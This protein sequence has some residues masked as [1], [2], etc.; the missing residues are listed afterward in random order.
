MIYR[1]SGLTLPEIP[2][3]GHVPRKI[4]LTAFSAAAVILQRESHIAEAGAA[5]MTGSLLHAGSVVLLESAARLKDSAVPHEEPQWVTNGLT[6][7]SNLGMRFYKQRGAFEGY[8][9]ALRW[10]AGFRTYEDRANL[11]N[12]SGYRD[13]PKPWIRSLDH[14]EPR[15]DPEPMTRIGELLLSRN[16]IALLHGLYDRPDCTATSRT[17]WVLAARPYRDAIG[18]PWTLGSLRKA[19]GNVHSAWITTTEN[20]KLTHHTLSARGCAIIEREIPVSIRGYGRYYGMHPFRR[21]RRA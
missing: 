4:T 16:E 17:D 21:Q 15:R 2:A 6:V 8:A 1:L 14:G 7:L 10:L 19:T 9:M 13:T 5:Y 12:I 20:G 18:G 11:R 3:Y